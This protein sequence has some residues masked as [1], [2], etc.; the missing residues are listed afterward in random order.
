V[1]VRYKLSDQWPRRYGGY[2]ALAK[3]LRE[4]EKSIQSRPTR[5]YFR[6]IRF[7]FAAIIPI[8]LAERDGHIRALSGVAVRD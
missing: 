1:N 2:P 4:S 8:G 6:V 7:P 3:A 5:N